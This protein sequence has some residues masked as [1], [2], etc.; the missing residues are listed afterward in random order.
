MKRSQVFLIYLLVL[1]VS[2]AKKSIIKNSEN[3]TYIVQEENELVN[4]NIVNFSYSECKTNCDINSRVVLKEIVNDTLKLLV[5]VHLNCA[6][7][8]TEDFN[9]NN[10][11]LNLISVIKPDENGVMVLADCYCFYHLYYEIYPV[12]KLPKKV[13]VNSEDLE[14]NNRNWNDN[15]ELNEQDYF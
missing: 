1:L 15:L 2:C 6:G 9:L 4:L 14:V 8:F 13:L 3:E 5:G 11:A 10:E 12:S 7:G